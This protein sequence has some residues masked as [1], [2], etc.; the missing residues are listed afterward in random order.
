MAGYRVR[1]AGY[2]LWMGCL[3]NG[4][5]ETAVAYSGGFIY[6]LCVHRFVLATHA[7]EGSAGRRRRNLE[8][9]ALNYRLKI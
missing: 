2:S 8:R 1:T 3:A 6:D 9:F 7:P 5:T 4:G